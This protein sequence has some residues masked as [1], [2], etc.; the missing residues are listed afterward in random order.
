MVP[1]GPIAT[2]L[3][4]RSPIAPRSVSPIQSSAVPPSGFADS[5][6][7][8][9]ICVCTASECHCGTLSEIDS[10]LSVERHSLGLQLR[11]LTVSLIGLG[12]DITVTA[13]DP[14]GPLLTT[15]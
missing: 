11:S 15:I 4:L 6:P 3:S 14:I 12:C 10:P 9:W 7:Q 2:D 1:P 5:T 13:D 8:M